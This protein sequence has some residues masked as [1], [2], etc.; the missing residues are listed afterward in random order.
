MRKKILILL[1]FNNKIILIIR[2]KIKRIKYY[3]H[4]QISSGLN[5]RSMIPLLN[6]YRVKNKGLECSQSQEGTKVTLLKKIKILNIRL[7]HKQHLQSKKDHKF[8]NI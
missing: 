4:H 6:L 7:D 3:N 1:I 5:H 8:L 2:L